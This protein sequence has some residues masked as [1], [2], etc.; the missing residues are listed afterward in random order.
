MVFSSILFLFFFMPLFM[1]AYFLVPFKFKNFVLLIFSL[2]FYAWGEPIY[3]TLMIFSSVVDYCNGRLIQ[4]FDKR[5]VLKRLFMILSIIINLSLLGFFKYADFA[6]ELVNDILG[7]SITQPNIA[8]PIGISFF[9][10]QT[11]SYSIDVYRGNIKPEHNFL[12]FMTYV[13]MFP[14]LIAG[15]IVRYSTVH[16]EL[17][18]REHSYSNFSTGMFIF[19]EGLFK[20]VL[21]AN[22][23]GLLWDTINTSGEISVAAAW[24]GSIAYTFQIYFDFSGY[25]D[26]AKGI[27]RMLGFTYPDNFNYP[28]IAKSITDFW[29]RWHMTLSTWFRDYLY[30]PLGGNRVSKAKHIRNLMIVWALTG[31]WH[32]ASLN[33]VLWGLLF[34]VILMLEKYVWGKALDKLP[35]LFRHI[36]AMFIV[37]F[38]FTIFVFDDLSA[39]GNYLKIEFFMTSNPLINPQF[40]DLLVNFGF[41]LVIAALLSTPIS[42]CIKKY[43][44]GIKSKPGKVL[45]GIGS[46]VFYVGLFL[47]CTAY[48]VNDTY[49][50]FLYFRF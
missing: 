10:F 29:R 23:M 37:I 28:F 49:N 36:Y 2:F 24:L 47:V 4:K 16:T 5:I 34:G 44:A 38:S 27:G 9:T 32:G 8:L 25:S 41:M 46:F 6:V 13:C 18:K 45:V 22:T 39:L 19:L 12:T 50:P 7:L 11:M 31:L 26:M 17:H 35:A 1:L 15:P 43:L 21:I 30:I 3:I 42:K 48:L 20:K 14:Q 33:F 40:F